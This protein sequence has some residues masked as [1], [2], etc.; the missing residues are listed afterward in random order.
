MTIYLQ[1]DRGIV[2]NAM[3]QT[4]GCGVSIACCS[5]LTEMIKDSPIADCYAVTG[6]SLIECFS[7][8][9]EEKRSAPHGRGGLTGRIGRLRPP[10]HEANP[11]SSGL[12]RCTYPQFYR[13]A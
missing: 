1:V 2:T 5:V 7:G 12:H 13:C 9:P 11:L 4:F 8:V 3:F 10:Y 6:L